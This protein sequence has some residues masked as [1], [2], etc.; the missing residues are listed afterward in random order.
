MLEVYAGP[1]GLG[2]GRDVLVHIALV[3]DS[4]DDIK[5]FKDQYDQVLDAIRP[6]ERGR[7]EDGSHW[8]WRLEGEFGYATWSESDLRVDIVVATQKDV[9]EAADRS[10]SPS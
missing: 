3:W 1:E 2:S 8:S 9:A 10:L 6:V 5:E 7:L 4:D